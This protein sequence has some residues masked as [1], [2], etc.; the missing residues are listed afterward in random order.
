MIFQCHTK[1]N[2]T[3]LRRSPQRTIVNVR[4]HLGRI[5]SLLL[6]T[7]PCWR[8][9][10]GRVHHWPY[11]KK[12]KDWTI[13]LATSY[14]TS[15]VIPQ[16]YF[17]NNQKFQWAMKV[18]SQTAVGSCE[19]TQVVLYVVSTSQYTILQFGQRGELEDTLSKFFLAK[20]A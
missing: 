20:L 16:S 12:K 19:K 10:L 15:L 17:C 8:L 4:V 2:G 3:D 18:R 9:L 14:C 1:I 11:L 7:L 5:F 6:I 13:F